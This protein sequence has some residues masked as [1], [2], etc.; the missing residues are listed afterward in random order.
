MIQGKII[1]VGQSFNGT[2]KDGKPWRKQE[3]IMEISGPYPKKLA[4]SVMN[5][6]I[7]NANLQVGHTAEIEIDAQSREYNGKWYTEVTAWKVNNR[8]IVNTAPGHDVYQQQPP[9]GYAAPQSN[10]Q[11]P[12]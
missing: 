5:D 6:K 10:N 9:Q 8:G 7:D 4:F 11:M 2:T 3:Y 1:A 12:F